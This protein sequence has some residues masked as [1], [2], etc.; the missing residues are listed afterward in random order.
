MVKIA[1]NLK[2]VF[3]FYNRKYREEVYSTKSTV[4]I[5]AWKKYRN[6]ITQTS[7]DINFLNSS[8]KRKL[9]SCWETFKF[10]L[11]KNAEIQKFSWFNK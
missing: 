7:H 3:M 10:I 11:L 9:C 8:D 4:Y 6:F 2:N 1:I 5:K